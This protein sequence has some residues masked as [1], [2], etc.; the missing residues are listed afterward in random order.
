MKGRTKLVL[1][2]CVA[3][4]LVLVVAIAIDHWNEAVDDAR[5]VVYWIGRLKEQQSQNDHRRSIKKVVSFGN[6]AVPLLIEDLDNQDER[7]QRRMERCLESIGMPAVPHLVAA[8][9]RD[10][11]PSDKKRAACS[12]V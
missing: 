5:P 9:G 2:L 8:L 10:N 11:P 3:T 7:V 1:A 12:V 6:A 4:S